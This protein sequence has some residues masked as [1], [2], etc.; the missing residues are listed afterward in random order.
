M[1]KWLDQHS[2]VSQDEY[3][4]KYKEFESKVQPIMMKLYN[5]GTG[6]TPN[7][8]SSSQTTSG[9]TIEEVN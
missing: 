7:M 1:Q 5:S 4:M 3:D 8:H 2:D 6:Y 9:P